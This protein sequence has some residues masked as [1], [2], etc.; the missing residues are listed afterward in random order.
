VPPNFDAARFEIDLIGAPA[1]TTPAGPLGVNKPLLFAATLYLSVHRGRP[2]HRAQLG[3]LL[4]PD[5]DDAARGERMR[6]LLHQLKRIG[7]T[8]P[9]RAPE[10]SLVAG[11]VLTDV[12]RLTAATSA[13][14]AADL[15]R[16]DVLAHFDPDISDEYSRWLEE[17]RSSVRVSVVRALEPWLASTRRQ[18]DWTVVEQ[19]ARRVLALDPLHPTATEA[20]TESIA[21][22]GRPD[23]F[24]SAWSTRAQTPL[25]G[26]GDV[27][28]RLLEALSEAEPSSNRFGIAGPP[29]IGKTRVLE[30][31]HRV[32][33]A[34]GIRSVWMRCDRADALRPLSLV[35][36]LA[37][38]LLQLRGALGAS[39]DSIEVLRRFTG[40][41]T[42][43]PEDGEN[44]AR[45][46]A[47]F[48][49]LKDLLEA[50]TDDGPLLVMIDDAQWVNRESWPILTPLFAHRTTAPIT[51]VVTLRVELLSSARKS[52]EEIFPSDSASADQARETHWLAPLT[53]HE[54]EALCAAHAPRAIPVE[55]LRAL[56][57]RSAGVPFI[58]RALTDHWM[59]TN[60]S[61]S[62][63]PSVTRLIQARLE[64]LS[65]SADR[66]LLAIAVLGADATVPALERVS[67]LSRPELLESTRELDTA[68]ILTMVD[69]SLLPHALWTESAITRAPRTVRQIV[70][71]Y[72]AE[73]LEDA[74]ASSHSVDVRRRW[75]LANHWLEA[76]EPNRAQRALESAAEVLVANGFVTQAAAAL[77]RAADLAGTSTTA[78]RYLERAAELWFSDERRDSVTNLLRVAERFDEVGVSLDPEFSPHH[79]IEIMCHRA[80]GRLRMHSHEELVQESLTCIRDERSSVSHK[81]VS[82]ARLFYRQGLAELDLHLLHGIWRDLNSSI[83]DEV[84]HT[85][86]Y[87]FCAGEYYLMVALSPPRALSHAEQFL[88]SV[89]QS[90]P[91][92]VADYTRAMGM[93]ALCHEWMGDLD[94][95]R[96]VRLDWLH[97]CDER[98]YTFLAFLAQIDLMAGSLEAGRIEEARALKPRL[99]EMRADLAP[100]LRELQ[101]MLLATLAI[102]ERDP[103]GARAAFI[104][105]L[106]AADGPYG[107]DV[108]TRVLAVYAHIALV[109]GDDTTACA[110]MA[111][112]RPWFATYSNLMEYPAYVLAMCLERFEAPSAAATFVRWYMDHYRK[113]KWEPR[114]ELRRYLALYEEMHGTTTN[115]AAP[116]QEPG[117]DCA[118]D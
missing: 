25:V 45:R 29:G 76:G 51:W 12:D 106:S 108:R 90:S 77:E 52:F 66:L 71:R 28:G 19:V 99:K 15:V 107:P 20:L 98:K 102:E 69:G 115:H 112:L 65:P 73:F 4:W 14:D 56:A 64:R 7:V 50:V 89:L 38:E 96:R 44:A 113:E 27:L 95:A 43:E 118:A 67:A 6:W 21:L 11:D 105:P 57:R 60:D 87:H 94:A 24:A 22:R 88:A 111:R 26:R 80:R 114:A 40:Q 109:T 110:L 91:L 18:G 54:V 75:G 58:A 85:R 36:D 46:A 3:A 116:D 48:R 13:S 35:V 39:P 41:S 93:I 97:L 10:L 1:I 104:F 8:A 92:D 63:P 53:S 42:A 55:T 78:M 5:A 86:E 74:E 100:E 79:D 117:K 61:T 31:L 84:R 103:E 16:G 33:N 23:A 34:R 30:E 32:A 81:L 62:L 82:A 17:V 59:L 37:R 83:A 49:A 70:H 47:V 68:G 101:S 72:A 2:V 9:A